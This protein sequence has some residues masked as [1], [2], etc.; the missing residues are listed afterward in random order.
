[1]AVA[2]RALVAP[3]PDSADRKSAIA[4]A[5]GDARPLEQLDGAPARADE[6]EFGCHCAALFR[7]DV[8]DT[9][10]PSAVLHTVQIHDAVFVMHRNAGLGGEMLYQQVSERA[11]IDI[12]TSDNA[13]C[14]KRLLVPAPV[15]DQ[16]RPFGDLCSLLGELH[17]VVAMACGHRLEAL[18][19]EG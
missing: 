16:R 18:A 11:V 15:H 3:Q 8:L 4:T 6:D 2:Y 9:H 13:S 5:L 17:P 1:M 14:R 12:R 7:V 10:P 19:Q